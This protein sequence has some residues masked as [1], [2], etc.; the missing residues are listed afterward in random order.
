MREKRLTKENE[1]NE[2]EAPMR[3][4]HLSHGLGCVMR[5]VRAGEKHC[6]YCRSDSQNKRKQNRP[7][8]P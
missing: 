4:G 5:F 2:G 7:P 1:G 3:L 6:G 8:I